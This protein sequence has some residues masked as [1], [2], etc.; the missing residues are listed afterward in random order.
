[1]RLRHRAAIVA[2]LLAS[3][4]LAPAAAGLLAPAHA[5]SI[6]CVARGNGGAIC[7]VIHDDG[8]TEYFEV[9]GG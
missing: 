6:N 5:M 4:F 7:E 9:A 8:T 2:T 3:S 1:M